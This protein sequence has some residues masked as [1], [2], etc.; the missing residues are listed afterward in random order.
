[1]E[2]LLRR[3]RGLG[4][5]DGVGT[6]WN[7]CCWRS[8]S[9]ARDTARR[10]DNMQSLKRR[11]SSL[12]A[13]FLYLESNCSPTHVGGMLVFEG[14]MSFERYLRFLEERIH[15]IPR[16]RQRLVEVP[17]NLAH[18]TL[19]DDPDF[20]LEN[21]VKRHRLRR[22]LKEPEVIEEALRVYEPPLDR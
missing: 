22:G 2:A 1:T 17:F 7:T 11:L 21:H 4:A 15:L 14:E 6:W 8:P 3:T 20:K 12:D 10:A 13:S 9:D 16:Y 19:E 5:V 18:A